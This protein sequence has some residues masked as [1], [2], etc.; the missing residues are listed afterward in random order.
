M[1]AR[2]D[3]E[4]F[5]EGDGSVPGPSNKTPQ[6][7]RVSVPEVDPE[8]INLDTIR[9]WITSCDEA[10]GHQ[11]AKYPG[12]GTPPAWLI[13]VENQRLVSSASLPD[14]FRYCALSYVWGQA[15][16]SKLTMATRDDLCKS[17]A[18][19]SDNP[20]VV[21][22]LT[23][24]HSI[25]LVKALG[26]KYLWV[27]A[28]CIVQ[29][30][31]AHFHAELR[32]MGAVYDKAYFT[33][34]AATGW[35]ANEGLKG[36]RGISSRRQLATNFADDLH[37]YLNPE[38]MI[39]F[40]RGW[41]FQEGLFSRRMLMFCGQ[42][43]I[44]KCIDGALDETGSLLED[45]ALKQGLAPGSGPFGGVTF[46][47]SME[48]ENPDAGNTEQQPQTESTRVNTPN[49]NAE[50]PTKQHTKRRSKVWK[51][52]TSP[53]SPT[54]TKQDTF[55]TPINNPIS[56][57]LADFT[58][59]M[60]EVVTPFNTRNFTQPS[61]LPRAFDGIAHFLAHNATRDSV[62]SQ[63]L[64]WG[65]PIAHM[66][67]AL[68][69]DADW[70][71]LRLRDPQ[72]GFPSWSWFAWE[73][74]V[75][76]ARRHAHTR[77]LGQRYDFSGKNLKF[78]PMCKWELFDGSVQSVAVLNGA[79]GLETRALERFREVKITGQR[80]VLRRRG[81]LINQDSGWGQPYYWIEEED[82][83]AFALV[84]LYRAK[85]LNFGPFAPTVKLIGEMV[86][87]SEFQAAG[88]TMV[89]ALWI[90]PVNKNSEGGSTREMRFYR[91]GVAI[92]DK[93]MWIR[94]VRDSGKPLVSI[95][96]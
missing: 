55:P 27:D 64:C 22:P 65:L 94:G 6:V 38:N 85:S 70:E 7:Q 63:G 46:L 61:D 11:C 47:R 80:S 84:Y 73:G 86:R 96:I 24:R 68:T 21:I 83:S 88:R 3:W 45:E 71:D 14:P 91:R 60:S 20:K 12:F 49:Q 76:S 42:T 58:T 54:K 95:L 19:S 23:I 48:R 13:D 34:V 4:S 35:D 53:F 16:T 81:E 69:W 18:L 15:K 74:S 1:A 56:H 8:W 44:W 67:H 75:T 82:S 62:F 36:L 79:D 25:D 9:S 92:L 5:L 66:P 89:K 87:I 17:G 93:H 50:K 57:N 10:W 32:N 90:E 26:E 51:K 78:E 31:D 29:D 2:R 77:F 39:W 52:L 41:T 43:A 37:K 28:F 33:V 30:D 72:L 59:Y 40:S